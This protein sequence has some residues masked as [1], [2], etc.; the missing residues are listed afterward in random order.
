MVFV[1]MVVM[2]NLFC[3]FL[4]SLVAEGWNGAKKVE[5]G[6]WVSS[7]FRLDLCGGAWMEFL[8]G[9]CDGWFGQG[10]HSGGIFV[11]KLQLFFQ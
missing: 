7:G 6:F 1:W 5:E 10:T 4:N 3:R 8:C 2:L 9:E 11:E